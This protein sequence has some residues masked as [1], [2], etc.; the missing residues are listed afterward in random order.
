MSRYDI[1]TQAAGEALNRAA[2]AEGKLAMA[3][4]ALAEV[5]AH[6]HVFYRGSEITGV[7]HDSEALRKVVELLDDALRR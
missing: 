7:G 5:R 2:V 4:T 3:R 6:F 1:V